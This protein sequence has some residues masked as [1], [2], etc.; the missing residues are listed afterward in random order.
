V[1]FGL[2]FGFLLAALLAGGRLFHNQ[3]L[4][5]LRS[6]FPNWKFFHALGWVPRLYWRVDA[7]VPFSEAEPQW[8]DWS[9][10]LPRYK[11][12]LSHLVFNAEVNLALSEQNLVEHL[13]SDIADS[14]EGA[15]VDP[16]VTYRMVE[17][18]VRQ[19]LGWDFP[20]GTRFQFCLCL[21]RLGKPVD[22]DDDR[23]LL[24]PDLRLSHG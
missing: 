12:R 1:P 9:L 6:F 11:R 4:F 15:S 23:V 21:H 20:E 7:D 14:G 22:L 17:K 16:F 3:W 13:S 19:K 18:M 2:Y 24:S 10:L 8:S 5:L